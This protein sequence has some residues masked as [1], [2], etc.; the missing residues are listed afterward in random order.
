VAVFGLALGIGAAIGALPFFS[1]SH[2]DIG[3]KLQHFGMIVAAGVLIGASIARRY[4]DKRGIE[5]DIIRQLTGWIVI[6]GF[7]GAH[8][9][10][11]LMYQQEKLKEDPLLILKLWDG[12]SSY[13]G[14]LGGAM[15][16]AFFVWWKRLTPGLIAD[17]SCIGLLHG[18][19]I[20]R[21]GCALVHDHIGRATTFWGGIDYPV[22]ELAERGVREEVIASVSG[23]TGDVIRAHNLGL[24]EL[25]YLIPVNLLVLWM[26]FG[27]KNARMPAGI[28]VIVTGLLYA[29]VRF[30]LE[31]LRLNISDPRY[32]G[33]TFAQWCS[34]AVTLICG[35]AAIWVWRRGTPAPLL[36]DLGG[37]PGGRRGNLPV[38][39]AK[40][41]EKADDKKTEKAGDKAE[42]K[43]SDDKKAE[44]STDKPKDKKKADAKSDDKTKQ[45]T[46]GEDP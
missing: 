16:W 1:I 46:D 14:F 7:I 45:S 12:I 34:I 44:T 22:A 2:F 17:I 43:K 36:A 23:P 9:F 13:G 28:I 37:K 30:F 27:R 41:A 5:D 6:S 24:Y 35:Y 20:G 19:S 25:I 15:G 42:S 33:F 31:Y 39:T 8:V 26:A 29:P 21:I 32:F 38:A 4:S 3:I 11:V 18:F 10:D 40:K